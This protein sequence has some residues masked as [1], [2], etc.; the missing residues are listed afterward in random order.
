[1]SQSRVKQAF[2]ATKLLHD[3]HP[4]VYAGVLSQS[5]VKQAFTATFKSWLRKTSTYTV[6]AIPLTFKKNF[7]KIEQAFT[8]TLERSRLIDKA[9]NFENPANKNICASKPYGCRLGSIALWRQ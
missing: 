9:P 1:M 7:L 6:V 5:R 4:A 2:T 8:A 3:A